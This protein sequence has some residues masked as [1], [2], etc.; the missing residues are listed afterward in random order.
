MRNINHIVELA[1]IAR[2]IGTL[3]YFKSNTGTAYRY[4]L[5]LLHLTSPA[6]VVVT[7]SLDCN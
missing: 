7:S 5:C 3:N 6:T 1:A 2:G 4:H